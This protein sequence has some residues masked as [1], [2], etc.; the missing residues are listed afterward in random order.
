MGWFPGMDVADCGSE[1][2]FYIWPGLSAYS[3]SHKHREKCWVYKDAWNILCW[4]RLWSDEKDIP[5][6]CNFLVTC[7]CSRV[8]MSIWYCEST[9]H[10]TWKPHSITV[11]CKTPEYLAFA[12][13]FNPISPSPALTH[14]YPSSTG[15]PASEKPVPD[16]SRNRVHCPCTFLSPRTSSSKQCRW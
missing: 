4:R 10:L 12:S 9:L 16:T 8:G 13:P 7:S 14:C 15:H 5:L 1:F 6:F 3:A 2:N 11:A